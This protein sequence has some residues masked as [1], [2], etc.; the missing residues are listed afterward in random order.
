MTLQ[1]A[2]NQEVTESTLTYEQVFSLRRNTQWNPFCRP[3][4]RRC[5]RGMAGNAFC[6][7]GK[8]FRS[9]MQEL[10]RRRCLDLEMTLQMFSMVNHEAVMDKIMT[11]S[12]D[13]TETT[14]QARVAAYFHL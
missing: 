10:A 14:K 2:Q 6:F 8:K 13:W 11:E 12:K 7:D 1:L 3:P 9:G 4:G 5:A